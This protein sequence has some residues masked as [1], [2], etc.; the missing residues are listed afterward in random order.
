MK[1]Y[2]VSGAGI[3]YSAGVPGDRVFYK[4]KKREK[5]KA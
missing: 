3:P 5:R 2:T 1:A 4:C